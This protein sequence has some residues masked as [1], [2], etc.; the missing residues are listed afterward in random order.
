MADAMRSEIDDPLA[1]WLLVTLCDYA[2]DQCVCWPST[3]TLAKRTGMGRS[4]VAKKLNTLIDAGYVS[5]ET[6]PFQSTTY[7]VYVG[8]RPVSD[9]DS[10]L[11]EPNIIPKRNRK[12]HVPDDWQPS[13]EVISRINKRHASV[14]IDHGNET[15]KFCDYHQSKGSTFVNLDKAYS[16]WCTKAV[17]FAASNSTRSSTRGGKSNKGDK[18]SDRFGEFIASIT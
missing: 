13:P 14:E 18:Q 11:L 16:N 6:N 10:N 1:K 3:F 8:D 4:T 12:M 5:R 9:V 17:E 15:N 7:R 2:N